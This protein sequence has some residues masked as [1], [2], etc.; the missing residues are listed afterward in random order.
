MKAVDDPAADTRSPVGGDA[1]RA[2]TAGIAAVWPRRFDLGAVRDLLGEDADQLCCDALAAGVNAPVWT[3]LD[4]GGGRWRPAICRLAYLASGGAAVVP[5]AVCQVAELLHTGSLV[6]DDI[7]DGSEV[8]RGGP[9]VHLVHGLPAAL[10]AANAA[11]FR[12]LEVLRSVL[13]DALRLRALD[14]LGEELFAAHLGQALDLSLGARMREGTVRLAHY[15]VLARAKTGALVR[16]AAR[17]GAIAAGAPAAVEAALAVWA[18]D[19]GVAYQIRNDCDDLVASMRDVATCRPAYPLLLALEEDGAA[20]R[21][22][23]ARLSTP[24]AC[25]EDEAL[26]RVFA[27]EQ[28]VSRALDTADRTARR[29]L[30]AL[31]SLPEGEGRCGLE[32]ITHELVASSSRTAA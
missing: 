5:A 8:R 9:A 7:Q 26:R 2:D 17:L 12:V 16:I 28:V 13:P 11:Y 22:L 21:L 32:R 10:N 6:I 15:V 20:A 3:L 30:D 31:R 29:A 25:G 27:D 1:A 19:L 24:S 18:S 23:R 4:R 14:M